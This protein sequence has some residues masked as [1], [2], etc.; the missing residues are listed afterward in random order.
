MSAILWTSFALL[1]LVTLAT[2]LSGGFRL[3]PFGW[4][5]SSSSVVR[6]YAAAMLVGAVLCRRERDRARLTTVVTRSLLLVALTCCAAFAWS[7]AA[8]YAAAADMFGY[9]SQAIDWSNGRLAHPEWI[10][11]TYFPASASVPLGYLYAADAAPTALALYPPGTSLHMAGVRALFGDWA[12]YLVSPIAALALVM[13]TYAM[14]KAWFSEATGTMAALLMAVNPVLLAQATVPMSDTLSAAYWTWSLTLAVNARARV[15]VCAG[16]LAGLAII[17]R[18]NLAPLAMGP[19]AAALMTSGVAGMTRLTLACAPLVAFLGWHQYHLYGAVLATGYGS[20]AQLF[21]PSYVGEN[22]RRYT[23]WLAR[24]SSPLPL[25]GFMIEAV[26]IAVR[27]Q[28]AIVPLVILAVLNAT[29]YLLYQPWPAWTFTRFLLP[30]LPIL[31]LMAV[32]AAHRV[33][34]RSPVIFTALVA[35][36]FG[37]QLAFAQASELR[38]GHEA[39]SRFK[40]LGTALAS[41]HLKRQPVITRSHSGSLRHYA[42]AHTYRWDQISTTELRDGITRARAAGLTPLIVDDSDDRA[43]FEQRHGPMHCWV[44][45]PTP[46]LTIQRHATANVFVARFGC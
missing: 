26:G 36:V 30:A 39:L 12:M 2:W 1:L 34:V 7:H 43:D 16:V 31:M 8:P 6:P 18:P 23:A 4:R 10:D 13:G 5:V 41:Q 44:D 17:V 40:E 22:A 28:F 46:V 37:W 11:T 25:T 19:V 33:T 14:G 45:S 15:Q 27:R 21:S 20:T 38:V 3:E 35:V 29:I 9:I 42:G 32:A 24:T